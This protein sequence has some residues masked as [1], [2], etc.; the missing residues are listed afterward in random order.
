M[1]NVIQLVDGLEHFFYFPQADWGWW[2][3]FRGV[4]TTNVSQRHTMSKCV[5]VGFERFLAQK[6]WVTAGGAKCPALRFQLKLT[7]DLLYSAIFSGLLNINLHMIMDIIYRDDIY[8]YVYI[9]MYIYI[10]ICIY[11]CIY[12]YMYIYIYVYIYDWSLISCYSWNW[13]SLLWNDSEVL[14]QLRSVISP[15]KISPSLLRLH[16]SLHQCCRTS[17]RAWHGCLAEDLFLGELRSVQQ[18]CKWGP[19][20]SAMFTM[21]LLFRS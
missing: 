7:I 19:H 14:P 18:L 6:I 15:L 1:K 16:L 9:Y 20:R 3:F 4:E 13:R 21:S 5:D 11:I 2:I 17:Q 8:I 12:I 10:Y